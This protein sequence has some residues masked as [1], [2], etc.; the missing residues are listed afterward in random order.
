MQFPPDDD[1]R[2]YSHLLTL[3]SVSA[4]MVGVCL[5]A[6]GL[7]RI[8]NAINKLEVMVEELLAVGA[9]IFMMITTL[10]FLGIRTGIRKK[11]R[12]FGLTLDVLFCLG[13]AVL[14]VASI[15][16]AWVVI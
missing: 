16:L 13:L 4:A 6:I 9:L 2:Y 8:L 1:D 14:V 15:L 10:S 3:L 11:W 12:R 5:T 7:V